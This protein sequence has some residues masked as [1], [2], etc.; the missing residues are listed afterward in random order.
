[1][2][3]RYTDFSFRAARQ[4]VSEQR[5]GD[6]ETRLYASRFSRGESSGRLR[7]VLEDAAAVIAAP[8]PTAPA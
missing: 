1:M 5:I 3:T 6:N 8:V 2:S 4:R 7:T